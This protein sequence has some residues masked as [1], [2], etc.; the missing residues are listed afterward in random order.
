MEIEEIRKEVEKIRACMMLDWP[1]LAAIFRKLRIIA[2]DKV[3][4]FGVNTKY[5]LRINPQFYQN[6]SLQGRVVVYCH[7]GLHIAFL[8]PHRGEN[9]EEKIFN[10]AA[11]C[12]V[13]SIL[14]AHKAHIEQF[15]GNPV[16]P[17]KIAKIVDLEEEKVAKMLVEELYW[18]LL[19]NSK[20]IDIDVIQD[21][22]RSDGK[23]D[24][25]GE[26]GKTSKTGETREGTSVTG[27]KV[28]QEGDPEA[29]K[30]GKT[31]KE[32][33]EYWRKALCDALV[34]AKMAGRL[35]GE[36][37]RIIDEL[38]KPKQNWKEIVRKELVS[39]LGRTVI[40]SWQIPSRKNPGYPGIKHLGLPNI[41]I[42]IDTSFSIGKGELGQFLGIV[43][44]VSRD[45]AKLIIVPWDAK[46]Y[47]PIVIRKLSDIRAL[48]FKGIPGGGGTVIAPAL[49]EGLK[50]TKLGDIS[51]VLTDGF[52]ADWQNGETQELFRKISQ[53]SSLSL[54]ASLGQQ[55]E[56]PTKWRKIKI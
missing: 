21:L 41:R 10:I 40:S 17:Q 43:F 42:Y 44:E 24:E 28:I 34:E 5:E 48:Q 35:P 53:K 18:L 9:K 54:F 6:I 50:S 29:Y 20:K 7:E 31:L 14:L 30:Q 49:T 46:V 45:R 55:I 52:I 4:T 27:E 12:M 11:D 2:D 36:V 25:A 23:S 39:G 8:H 1:F 51:M 38:I 32:T 3:P 26:A 13:N 47:P 19:E 22:L 37:E 15:P 33:E 16:T 56:L